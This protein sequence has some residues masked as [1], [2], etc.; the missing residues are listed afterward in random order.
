M[1]EH[2]GVIGHDAVWLSHVILGIVIVVST[3]TTQCVLVTARHQV[4]TEDRVERN[5]L[6]RRAA[7]LRYI[8]SQCNNE[9]LRDRARREPA[10]HERGERG[11]ANEA[12]NSPEMEKSN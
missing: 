12:K 5:E 10:R 9:N 4:E 2:V 1:S 3:Q 11:D 7:G 8:Q 6:E